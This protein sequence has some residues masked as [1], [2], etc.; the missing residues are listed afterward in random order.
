MLMFLHCLPASLFRTEATIALWVMGLYCVSNGPPESGSLHYVNVCVYCVSLLLVRQL[1]EHREIPGSVS[2]QVSLSSLSLSVS[3]HISDDSKQLF[4]HL[5]TGILSID[6][7]HR[8]CCLYDA[9]TQREQ[10]V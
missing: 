8:K 9:K 1:A 5:S 10:N 6:C 7:A 4:T 2:E 3:G